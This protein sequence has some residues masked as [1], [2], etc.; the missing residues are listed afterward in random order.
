MPSDANALLIAATGEDPVPYRDALR[1]HMP[2]L[3]IHA[4]GEAYDPAT[5]GYS[6]VWQPA[7]GLMASLPNL[8]AIFS[9]GAGIDHILA[10][11]ALPAEVPIVRLMHDKTREQMR[12][13]VLH[14]VLH[15]YRQMDVAAAQQAEGAWR[16][17]QIRDK[18]A[19]PVGFLGMGEMGRAAATALA[20]L[21]FTVM[22]WSR[23]PKD[24]P[25]VE[26]HSGAEGLAAMLA[27]TRFLISVL[28]ATP[29]TV[30]L[31]DAALFAQLPR[32][33]VVVNLGR[34][35]HL[36]AGDLLAALDS[37][38]VGAA[39]LDVFDPEPVPA[40]S[41][42]WTHPGVRL[43]PHIGSD[44]NAAICGEAVSENIR[45]MSAGGAPAPLGDRARGY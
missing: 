10:D 38:Q 16:F 15:Y 13:Y 32:G 1:A 28:P 6:L 30:G 27:R 26:C 19:L 36:V 8:K 3:E 43:T 21:G 45:R 18:A 29:D 35:N 25:G 5:I 33:A 39:T 40:D 44:G 42:F 24:I 37:G 34:G 14:A 17:L 22:G 23:S 12:D 7:P 4:E 11:P 31:L 41:P 2:D 20:G 9:M